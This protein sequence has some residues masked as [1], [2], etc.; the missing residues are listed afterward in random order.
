MYSHYIVIPALFFRGKGYINFVPK[1]IRRPSFTF[2]VNVPLPKPLE[3]ATSN[4][5]AE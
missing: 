5:V 4:S 3:L 2:L 1:S